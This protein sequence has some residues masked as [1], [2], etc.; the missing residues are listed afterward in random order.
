MPQNKKVNNEEFII[1][2][3]LKLFHKDTGASDDFVEKKLKEK[4]AIQ[5][6]QIAIFLRSLNKNLMTE[7]EKKE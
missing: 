2:Q 6:D 3:I 1:D 7:V 5:R 4:Q